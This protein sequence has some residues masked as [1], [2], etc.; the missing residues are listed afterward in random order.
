[1]SEMNGLIP[2]AFLVQAL[3]DDQDGTADATAWT[4]VLNQV[5]KLI[6]GPLSVRYATPFANPLPPI[7]TEAAPILAAE[8]LY[9][10][11]GMGDDQ[12]PWVKQATAVRTKLEKIAAGDLPLFPTTKRV[13]PSASAVTEPAKA[14]SRRG[15]GAI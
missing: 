6:D 1:M 14:S 3:D 12:N 7:V 10:R 2:V 15:R 13:Q 4:D 8:L 11:R 9:K 5:H